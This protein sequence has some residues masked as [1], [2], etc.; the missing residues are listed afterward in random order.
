MKG[1]VSPSIVVGLLAILLVGGGCATTSSQS[2]QYKPHKPQ[3]IT[4]EEEHEA[5]LKLPDGVAGFLS[6]LG[7]LAGGSAPASW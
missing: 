1:R 3:M 4:G 5:T 7:A 6:F 2:A